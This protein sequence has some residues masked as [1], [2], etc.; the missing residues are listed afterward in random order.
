MNET[1]KW[2]DAETG[3]GEENE[4]RLIVEARSA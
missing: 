3:K 4:K 1:E 2:E